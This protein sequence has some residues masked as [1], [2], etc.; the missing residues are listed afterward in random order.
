M[1]DKFCRFPPAPAG[2]HPLS[3]YSGGFRFARPPATFSYSAVLKYRV[4]KNVEIQA[5]VTNLTDEYYY[6]GVH[7]GHVVPGEGRTL[8]ISTNFK[9]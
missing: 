1:Q 7:P 9:F 2:A 3:G 6:D 4:S 5:N 8:F